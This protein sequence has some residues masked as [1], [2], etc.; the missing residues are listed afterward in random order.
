[1]VNRVRISGGLLACIL[2]PFLH[3]ATLLYLPGALA[4]FVGQDA[5][6][7]VLTGAL[8]GLLLAWLAIWVSLRHPGLGPVQLARVVLGTWLGWLVGLIYMAHFT[9]L[10]S[11]V[12]RNVLDFTVTVLLPMTPGRV[13][14]LVLGLVVLNGVWHGLEPVARMGF[15]VMVVI[16]LSILSLPILLWREFSLL[17]LSPLFQ[18]ELAPLVHSSLVTAGWF[19]E[20]VILLTL[21]PHLSRPQGAYRWTLVGFALATTALL[22]LVFQVILV[23]GPELPSR[24]IFP[25]YSLIQMISL[26]DFIERIELLLILVWLS[27]MFIKAALCLYAASEAGQHLLGL[28]DHRWTAAVLT[29]TAVG[30]TQ[31]W[32]RALDLVRYGTSL[33]GMLL[34]NAVQVGIVVLLL[35]G[36]L[37][38][39][40]RQGRST[41]C[42]DIQ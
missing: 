25:T 10:L 35:L 32:P 38:H 13:T 15:Q 1:M 40:A 24:F 5:W 36:T 30:L 6:M 18:T 20:A 7:P 16:M 19:G 2:F 17:T 11:L 9:W 41:Q 21:A 31:V 8:F 3:S 29:L 42:K 14:A 33:E 28:R 23:L 4:A 22:T 12:L 39:A 27:G 37:L 26:A 34:Y